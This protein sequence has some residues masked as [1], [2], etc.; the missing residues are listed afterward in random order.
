MYKII[1]EVYTDEFDSNGVSVHAQGTS[2][3]YK[4]L[5]TLDYIEIWKRVPSW[6]KSCVVKYENDY[7]V[8]ATPADV[9]VYD[10]YTQFFLGQF[11]NIESALMVA[12]HV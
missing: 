10:E 12:V 7:M 1:Y 2:S 4:P 9:S 5:D 8:Y 11:D 3:V 6:C